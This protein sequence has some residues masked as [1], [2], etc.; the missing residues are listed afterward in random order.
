MSDK[1]KLGCCI[2]GGSFMPQGVSG[3]GEQALATF[4]AGCGLVADAGFDYSEATVG[5]AMKLSDEETERACA[6]GLRISYFNSFIPGQYKILDGHG[7]YAS[8]LGY[9]AAAAERVQRLGGK[10]I[11]LGSGAARRI[12]EGMGASEAE[13]LFTRFCS[14]VSAILRTRGIT[15]AL[16]PLNTSETNM[17]NTLE[18]GAEF[19]DRVGAPNFKLLCDAYHMFRAGEEPDEAA[20]F[21]QLIC[22][23]HVAEPPE[24]VYPG[25]NGGEYL[26]GLADALTGAGYTGVVTAECSFGSDLRAEFNASRAFMGE[27]FGL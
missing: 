18:Q 11:V 17:I 20:K 9:A 27:I 21:A 13:K 16:E 26:R 19:V 4:E 2:P 14:E 12:P 23:V 22:H 1:I 3:T 8:A 7:G 10:L 15:L 6:D 5:A 25:K 24:R